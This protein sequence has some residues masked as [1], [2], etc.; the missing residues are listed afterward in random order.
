MSSTQDYLKKYMSKPASLDEHKKRKLKKKKTSSTKSTVKKGNFAIHDEDEVS[1]TNAVASDSDDDF[2]VVEQPKA[3]VYKSNSSSWSTVREGEPEPSR[4]A[5]LKRNVVP[6]WDDVENEDERPSIAGIVV[7]SESSARL[8]NPPKSTK[9]SGLKFKSTTPANKGRSPSPPQ[10]RSPSPDRRRSPS[11]AHGRARYSRS[12]SRSRSPIR[13]KRTRSTSRSLSPYAARNRRSPSPRSR[14][15]SRS[16][17]P[18]REAGFG[19]QTADQVKREMM[20][21]REKEQSNRMRASN[22]SGGGEADTIY[23]DARGRKVDRVQEKLEAAEAAR[24]DIEKLERQMEWGKGLVQREAE[25]E[26]KKR[27]QEEKLKPLARYKDDKDLNEELKER[28]RWNDPAA[29]FLSG[30]KKSKK[31]APKFPL[32]QG[33]FPSNRF[34][35]RPG[36]RWDGVD[37][38]TGFEKDYIQR[39]NTRKNNAAEAHM[40]SV[41]DM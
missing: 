16:R 22:S 33:N 14:S 10:R 1:W 29:M 34:N 28:D 5:V 17:S 40:W 37:R 30:T 24:R 8:R 39:I 7:E 11:L 6:E 32:Y 9:S 27:E 15:R 23:R 31:S 25:E 13:Q 21:Q 19:L 12:P 36:Y 41:E 18:G 2:P 4:E 26:K 20:R 38:S 35:I 3:P